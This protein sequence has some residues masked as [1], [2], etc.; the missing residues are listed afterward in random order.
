MSP[1]ARHLNAGTLWALPDDSAVPRRE[2]GAIDYA[3]IKALGVEAIQHHFIDPAVLG[4]GLDMTAMG[5][6]TSPEEARP[7]AETQKAQGFILSTWHVGVG[8]ETDAEMDA[9]A[10]AVL[11]ASAATGHPIHVETHRATMTQDIRRTLDL[12]ARFPDLTFN[13]DLSH[14]YTGH[15]MTYGDFAAKLDVMAPIFARVR[16]MHG[17]IGTPCCAQ[18]ALSG[19]DDK[20]EFVDHF[21]Q[22]WARCV[23]GFVRASEPGEVL[24]F[25]PELLP[26]EID[27]GGAIHKLYYARQFGSDGRIREESDRWTQAMH[28]FEIARLSVVAGPDAK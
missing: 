5:R 10:G 19:S 11:D 22:M 3:A 7:L 16:Y 14:W 13:A 28:L 25:A 27:F 12:V 20:R 23:A 17:R 15:E 9:L 26:Y 24:P 18:V 8:L 4:A 21:R 6:I 1:I 2:D